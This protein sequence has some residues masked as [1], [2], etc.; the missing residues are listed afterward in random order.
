MTL[1]ILGAALTLAVAWGGAWF[2]PGWNRNF[3]IIGVGHLDGRSTGA[4]PALAEMHTTWLTTRVTTW[5]RIPE[6]G[7]AFYKLHTVV[8]QAP[9][10]WIPDVLWC[11]SSKLDAQVFRSGDRVA[12]TVWS[13]AGWPLRA[14]RCASGNMYT[15]DAKGWMIGGTRGHRVMWKQG[16]PIL[17]PMEP[18]WLG[19]VGNTLFYALLLFVL[20]HSPSVIRRL[21]RH[22]RGQCLNCGYDR[23]G[24]EPASPCPECG[25][26]RARC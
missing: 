6:D 20:W 18:V 2:E 9:P 19:L 10:W 4:E 3:K 23:R 7:L 11:D 24:H 1:G 8:P 14:F 21:V 22:R 17:M 15:P 12:A 5:S 25:V 16:R 26:A 13:G